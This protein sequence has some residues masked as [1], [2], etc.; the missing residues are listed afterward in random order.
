MILLANQRE[1]EKWKDGRLFDEAGDKVAEP[2]NYPCFVYT[3][4]ISWPYQNQE[5]HYLDAGDL[6]EML[7]EINIAAT[8]GRPTTVAS[9]LAEACPNC[10][11]DPGSREHVVLCL[12][13]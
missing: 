7:Q 4:V 12:M 2:E 5:A 1:F 10:G 11:F 9:D 3:T 13:E 6:Y 8:G